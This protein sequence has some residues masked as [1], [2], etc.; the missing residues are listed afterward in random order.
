MADGCGSFKRERSEEEQI[1]VRFADAKYRVPLFAARKI[2]RLAFVLKDTPDVED[3]TFN[4]C[5]SGR[6]FAHVLATVLPPFDMSLFTG[7]P[8]VLRDERN[9]FCEWLLYELCSSRSSAGIA[10]L[11]ISA[12]INVIEVSTCSKPYRLAA[13]YTDGSDSE[14]TLLIRRDWMERHVSGANPLMHTH[15]VVLTPDIMKTKAKR[16]YD[17][18][19]KDPFSFSITSVITESHVIFFATYTRV[20]EP[21]MRV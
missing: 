21:A 18:Y 19:A 10:N 7:A 14:S 5:D 4:E 6:G 20:T 12:K 8:D 2:P 17:G 11:T 3:V 16:V 15:T 9:A 13:V 1:V